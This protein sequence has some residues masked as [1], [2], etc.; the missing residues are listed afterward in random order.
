MSLEEKLYIFLWD[1]DNFLPLRGG[2]ETSSIER[3]STE[4]E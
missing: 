3:P 1:N 2:K 4:K